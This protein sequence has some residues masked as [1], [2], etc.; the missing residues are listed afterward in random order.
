VVS[1]ATALELA[2]RYVIKK[3]DPGIGLPRTYPFEEGEHGGTLSGTSTYLRQRADSVSVFIFFNNVSPVDSVHYAR[4]FYRLE[5]LEDY[6]DTL[7]TWPEKCIGGFW[8]DPQGTSPSVYGSYDCPYA[9]L[10]QGLD[11]LRAGSRV[12][13]L[14]G[15]SDWTGTLSKKLLLRAPLETARIGVLP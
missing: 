8:V 4:T 3:Y 15:N 14:G 1:A 5:G 7:Q 6:L 12:N 9:D 2:Q 11:S 10:D 13:F